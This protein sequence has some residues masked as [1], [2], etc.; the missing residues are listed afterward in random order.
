MAAPL[1][2]GRTSSSHSACRTAFPAPAGAETLTRTLS[3]QNFPAKLASHKGLHRELSTTAFLEECSEFS[4]LNSQRPSGPPPMK[5]RHRPRPLRL[6]FRA[7]LIIEQRV[8]AHK[9]PNNCMECT[10]IAYANTWKD[11]RNSKGWQSTVPGPSPVGEL[12]RHYE[13]QTDPS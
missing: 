13:I 6:N 8:K 10:E 5:S 3:S 4:S 1:G 9:P 2:K 7:S 12:E 11:K